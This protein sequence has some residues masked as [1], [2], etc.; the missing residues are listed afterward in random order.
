MRAYNLDEMHSGRHSTLKNPATA[1]WR[2]HPGA[3]KA[4]TLAAG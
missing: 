4:Q 2:E 1:E 3:S